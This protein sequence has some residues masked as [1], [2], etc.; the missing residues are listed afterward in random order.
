MNL[1]VKSPV[2]SSKFDQIFIKYD[3]VCV[4]NYNMLASEKSLILKNVCDSF[5]FTNPVKKEICFTKKKTPT[6]IDVVLT[7]SP[8]D[9][10]G[11]IHFD[12]GLSDCHN[13]L[14]AV[15]KENQ[16]EKVNFRSY[17]NFQEAY[18]IQDVHQTPF[19]IADISWHGT[20]SQSPWSL[21]IKKDQNIIHIICILHK[22]ASLRSQD[23]GYP[24]SH[25]EDQNK[26][27]KTTKKKKKT[28]TG[29]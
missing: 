3:H 27:Q 15:F 5:N 29:A 8:N 16:R 4:L 6:L 10:F 11:T 17:E 1:Q 23:W 18:F 12:C 14:A 26:K 25:E 24:T 28:K 13:M 21:Q 7:N 20:T 2:I 22:L 9:L 19:H